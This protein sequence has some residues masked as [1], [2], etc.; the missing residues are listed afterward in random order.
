MILP[1]YLVALPLAKIINCRDAPRPFI[2]GFSPVK[3]VSWKMKNKQTNEI[4]K[5]KVNVSIK[6]GKNKDQFK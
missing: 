2:N 6:Q 3:G 1:S 4:N 5:N